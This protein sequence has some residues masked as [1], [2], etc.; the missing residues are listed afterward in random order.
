MFPNISQ[1][2]AQKVVFLFH[3]QVNEAKNLMRTKRSITL[4]PTDFGSH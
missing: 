2:N 1:V 4:V 3:V